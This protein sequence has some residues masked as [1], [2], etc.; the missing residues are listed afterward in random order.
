MGNTNTS[1]TTSSSFPHTP[2][3]LN[4]LATSPS[5]QITLSNTQSTIDDNML[6]SD[7]SL[8][9]DSSHSH[10]RLKPRSSTYL[11]KR[12]PSDSSSKISC[13]S[14]IIK[15]EIKKGKASRGKMM[16]V[17]NKNNMKKNLTMVSIRKA[18]LCISIGAIENLTEEIKICENPFISKIRYFFENS[19][20][21]YFVQ[22]FYEQSNMRNF[23]RKQ[24]YL[25][26]DEIRFYAAQIILALDQLPKNPLLLNK[27]LFNFNSKKVF[28]DS[29]G[30]TVL[31]LLSIILKK[32]NEADFEE[33]AFYYQTPE[34]LEN[35][36]ISIS[37]SLAWKLGIILYEMASGET[38]FK[39]KEDISSRN[40]KFPMWFSPVLVDL[41][42]KLLITNPSKRL[43]QKNLEEI[44]EHEFFKGIDWESVKNKEVSGP[45]LK[46]L[47]S[48]TDFGIVSLK[49]L[50]D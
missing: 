18:D 47:G 27:V 32:E 2:N 44:K 20:H 26:E 33:D 28:F 43:G 31:N 38:P 14:F 15:S 10:S 11:V 8:N 39:S 46:S 34:T 22:D 29:D 24:R 37:S 25:K 21:I 6:L 48:E 7:S 3:S 35:A 40:I 23:L 1:F 4:K 16:V 45:I 41:L 30:H 13:S 9:L 17:A 42:E 36:K 12:S 50:G 19:S 5:L 49:D